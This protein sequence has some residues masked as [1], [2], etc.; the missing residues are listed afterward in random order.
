MPCRTILDANGHP[1][2]IACSRGSHAAPCS[3]PG[4]GRSHTKLCDFPLKGAKAGKTCDAK[5][6]DRCA[7]RVGKDTDYCPAHARVAK[8]AP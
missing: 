2:G 3:A 8:E 6:C 1:I 4:C 5:L 7:V